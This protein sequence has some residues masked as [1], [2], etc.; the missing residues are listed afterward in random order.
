MNTQ[1]ILDMTMTPGQLTKEADEIC[2]KITYMNLKQSNAVAEGNVEG[3]KHFTKQ[4]ASLNARLAVV[5]E[6]L[7]EF[8]RE[9]W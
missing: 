4:I 2:N 5:L 9:R 6:K 1:D 8:D 3:A 7:D